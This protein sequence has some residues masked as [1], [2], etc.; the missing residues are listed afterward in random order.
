VEQI[1]NEEG[2]LCCTPEAI[3]GAFVNY[4]SKLFTSARPRNME[5]CTSAISRESHRGDEQLF[6]G[7]F[8]YGRNKT[9]ARSNGL[10]QSPM[11]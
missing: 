9:G 5:D 2:I 1:N 4:F 3:E 6:A 11:T 10:I 8:H 7:R